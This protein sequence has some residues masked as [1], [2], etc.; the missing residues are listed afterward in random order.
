MPDFL[1]TSIIIL[2]FHNAYKW[3]RHIGQKSITIYYNS[4]TYRLL[5]ELWQKIKICFRYSFLERITEERQVNP[6]ILDNSK[7][8]QYLMNLY[9]KRKKKADFFLRTSLAIMLTGDIKKELYSY[10]VRILSL[11]LVAIILI[12]AVFAVILQRQIGLWNFWI[13]ILFL[14]TATAGLSCE[15]DWPTIK[16]SSIFLKKRLKDAEEV[17]DFKDNCQT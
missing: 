9:N 1:E 7:S 12:N 16:E 17:K 3:C 11:S 2:F 4:H 15:A 8:A 14:L 13:S 6:A 10:P 5:N